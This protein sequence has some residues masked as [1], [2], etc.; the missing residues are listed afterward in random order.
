MSASTDRIYRQWIARNRGTL[1]AGKGA[2]VPGTQRGPLPPLTTVG[3]SGLE[4]P[5]GGGVLVADSRAGKV[6][7]DPLASR[8]ESGLT[9]CPLMQKLH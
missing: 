8:P 9:I 1:S 3:K 6:P 4:A 2:G 7:S 5:A